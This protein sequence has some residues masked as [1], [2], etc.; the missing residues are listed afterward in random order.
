MNIIYNDTKKDLPCEQLYQLFLSA[1]WTSKNIKNSWLEQ[2]NHCFIN[3]TLVI[4]AWSDERLVGCVRVLSDE[5]IRSHIYDL[6][7]LPEYKSKGI[8]TELVKRCIAFCPKSEWVVGCLKE[9]AS[10]YEKIGFQKGD[11]NGD[12]VILTIPHNF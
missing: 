7:V 8:G 9:R 5:I 3:S 11:P 2:F 12:G 10:F 1:G 6:V 4:S